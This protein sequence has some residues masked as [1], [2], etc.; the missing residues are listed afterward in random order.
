MTNNP[1]FT[2]TQGPPISHN[3][4]LQVIQMAEILDEYMTSKPRTRQTGEGTEKNKEKGDHHPTADVQLRL[5]MTTPSKKRKIGAADDSTWMA[6]I[7]E[8]LTLQ[9][10]KQ[11]RIIKY[12][13]AITKTQE[14]LVNL[15][16]ACET[17]MG[18]AETRIKALQEVRRD[19]QVQTL[20]AK[21]VQPHATTPHT[22]TVPSTSKGGGAGLGL[23]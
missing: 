18:V 7:R 1:T 16:T 22:D 21:E 4:Q 23:F 8:R 17:R 5:P 11:D 6:E 12:L 15:L 2:Q 20:T 10:E 13:E 9:D 14:S 3:R 19:T